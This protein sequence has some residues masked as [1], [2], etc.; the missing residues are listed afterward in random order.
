M[1]CRMLKEKLVQ[2]SVIL[3]EMFCFP[4]TFEYDISAL[5]GSITVMPL[6]ASIVRVFKFAFSSISSPSDVYL[7]KN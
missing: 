2:I 6:F 7:K 4:A 1:R 5:K 3:A